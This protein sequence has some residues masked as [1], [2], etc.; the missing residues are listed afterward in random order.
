MDR[1]WQRLVSGSKRQEAASMAA[2]D[3][4]GPAPCARVHVKHQDFNGDVQWTRQADGG[5]AW[6]PKFTVPSYSQI[7]TAPLVSSDD[8]LTMSSLFFVIVRMGDHFF[9]EGNNFFF[10]MG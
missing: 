6:P 2:L 4:S 3:E 8:Q 5:L 1:D 9:F 7:G 10:E